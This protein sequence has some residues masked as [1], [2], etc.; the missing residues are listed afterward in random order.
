[1]ARV[2]SFTINTLAL[3]GWAVLFG[4]LFGIIKIEHFLI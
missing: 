3:L 1:M 2:L 4:L